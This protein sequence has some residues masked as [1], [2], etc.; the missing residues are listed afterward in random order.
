M[1]VV[2][3]VGLGRMGRLMSAHLVAAGHEVRGFDLDPEAA[4][5]GVERAGECARRRRRRRRR[6]HDAALAGGRALGDARAGRHRGGTAPGA[7][8]IDMSTAPPGLARELAGALAARGIEALDAPVSGGTIGAEAGT[9]TIM[10][11]GSA[12]GHRARAAALRGHGKARRARRRPRPRAGGQALQQPLRGRQ[13]G[14]DRPGARAGPQRGP[15]PG[16]ALRADDELD[17]RLAR[18][19]HALPGARQRHDAGGARLRA[20][21]SRSI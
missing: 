3:F 13:H 20:R 16:R 15:R 7:L 5:E 6:D 8:C 12:G 19:A 17:R 14:G 10:V 9:L 2:A 11:G 1:T 18:P 4:V 21:C